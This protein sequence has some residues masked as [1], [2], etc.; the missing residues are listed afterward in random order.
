MTS[1]AQPWDTWG[2]RRRVRQRQGRAHASC[3]SARGSFRTPGP[4]GRVCR[5]ALPVRGRSC[6][7]PGL[8]EAP[9]G[10]AW[11][12]SSR[13]Q[14]RGPGSWHPDSRRGFFTHTPVPYL[15]VTSALFSVC[16]SSTPARVAGERRPQRAAV[17]P[18]EPP[19]RQLCPVPLTLSLRAG[20]GPLGAVFLSLKEREQDPSVLGLVTRVSVNSLG[21]GVQP[22]ELLQ[23]GRCGGGGTSPSLASA[24]V[25]FPARP[26]SCSDVARLTPQA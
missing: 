9:I 4:P 23:R 2:G 18:A 17:P 8:R 1:A 15:L 11:E 13:G 6:C 26:P 22:C 7:S 14:E 19:S 21:V 20:A 16:L 10:Q 12:P 25:Q 24:R 5:G 3:G